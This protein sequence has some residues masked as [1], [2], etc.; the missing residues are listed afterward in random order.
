MEQHRPVLQP[1]EVKFSDLAVRSGDSPPKS[2]R[3][4]FRPTPQKT[5][6]HGPKSTTSRGSLLQIQQTSL[7]QQQQIPFAHP[8]D[9]DVESDDDDKRRGRQGPR[10]GGAGALVGDATHIH[11][12]SH[13]HN[14]RTHKGKNTGRTARST[15]PATA[16]LANT[17]ME[18]AGSAVWAE[19]Y[20]AGAVNALAELRNCVAAERRLKEELAKIN[21]AKLLAFRGVISV[22][23]AS[24]K[25]CGK[26][27]MVRRKAGAEFALAQCAVVAQTLTVTIQSYVRA[28]QSRRLTA[29]R[30]YISRGGLTS[31]NF[32]EE[33]VRMPQFQNRINSEGSI[34][35]ETTSSLHDLLDDE[36]ISRLKQLYFDYYDCDVYVIPGTRSDSSIPPN[37]LLLNSLSAHDPFLPE[38][39]MIEKASLSSSSI[40]SIVE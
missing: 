1:R 15:A 24:V 23:L 21:A 22:Y 30:S 20:A 34:L 31:E 3:R 6:T 26:P 17:R 28:F 36:E 10:D 5:H 14:V 18:I 11:S 32:N 29:T 25:Q 40:S 13:T 35:S 2:E 27:T 38:D 33:S 39:G 9:G 12:H 37:A 4:G 7:S 19:D 8:H 16:E